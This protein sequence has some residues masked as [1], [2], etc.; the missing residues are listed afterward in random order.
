MVRRNARCRCA[1]HA[2]GRTVERSAY[3]PDKSISA[4]FTVQPHCRLWI[5]LRSL[6][7]RLAA[8]AGT[9]PVGGTSSQFSSV[10][11][12]AQGMSV[13]C[14]LSPLQVGA[15][16]VIGRHH[17]TLRG[18][19]PPAPPGTTIELGSRG[20]IRTADHRVKACCRNRLATRLCV[21]GSER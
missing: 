14:G 17:H 15:G 4:C 1:F 8:I 11:P 16:D 18:Y 13:R 9:T 3:R 10:R 21:A 2:G 20:R 19:F 6:P 5:E 12:Y 7:E